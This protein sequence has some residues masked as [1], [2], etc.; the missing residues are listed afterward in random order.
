MDK[1][2]SSYRLREYISHSSNLTDVHFFRD[3]LG[4]PRALHRNLLGTPLYGC[5]LINYWHSHAIT[6][7]PTM[8]LSMPCAFT[9]I[10]ILFCPVGPATG[11]VKHRIP[12]LSQGRLWRTHCTPT[13]DSSCWS[14]DY[15]PQKRHKTTSR[16]PG[17]VCMLLYASSVFSHEMRSERDMMQAPTV[18]YPAAETRKG[19][20]VLTRGRDRPGSIQL[21][22]LLKIKDRCVL[23]LRFLS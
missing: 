5:F 20:R 22:S 1:L 8:P 23:T 17:W 7:I 18:C 11:L 19:H 12:H 3:P 21:L 4:F 15:R 13:S 2:P 6:I 10:L 9:D 16:P 14:E